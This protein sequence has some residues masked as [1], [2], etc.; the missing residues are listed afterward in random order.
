M[1]VSA[2]QRVA[3]TILSTSSS[4]DEDTA[5]L[6][7]LALIFTRNFLPMII[8][9]DSGWLRLTGITARPQRDLGAHELGI[10][11]VRAAAQYAISSVIDA[12]LWR[13]PAGCCCLRSRSAP[14]PPAA[15]AVHAWTS[16]VALWSVY[17][18]E[19]SY[20]SKC[21]PLVRLDPANRHPD[22]VVIDL[23]RPGIGPV[24]ITGG[25]DAVVE[26]ASAIPPYAGITRSGSGGRRRRFETANQP[27]SQPAVARAPAE[28]MFGCRLPTLATTVIRCQPRSG[29]T[30]R[31]AG[32]DLFSTRF[33]ADETVHPRFG[34]ART[35]A[36]WP[37]AAIRCASC[38]GTLE[39]LARRLARAVRGL[40][41]SPSS[42]AR[43]WAGRAGAARTSA[44]TS[45]PAST[46]P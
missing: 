5:E 20:R 28:L 14:R 36:N 37:A 17:G 24:V 34:A 21:S 42:P 30:F 43:S 6:P 4:I 2:P 22:A 8:G 25:T 10:D 31:R 12:R 45:G 46:W 18:P 23:V 19:V 41:A 16:I 9:S 32:A 7:M 1:M 13:S 15:R 35:A 26:H 27:P 11:A 3:H 38:T 29:R 40:A 33:S 44:R 39:V